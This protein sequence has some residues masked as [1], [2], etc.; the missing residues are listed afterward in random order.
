MPE[1][2]GLADARKYEFYLGYR[3]IAGGRHLGHDYCKKQIEV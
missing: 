2:L 1:K 3:I